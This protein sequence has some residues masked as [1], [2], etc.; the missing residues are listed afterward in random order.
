MLSGYIPTSNIFG[1]KGAK[2]MSSAIPVQLTFELFNPVLADYSIK[3]IHEFV[4]QH[5]PETI[6]D[7]PVEATYAAHTALGMS[8]P[9]L[10]YVG[11][12][13][14]LMPISFYISDL[15][16]GPPGSKIKSDNT[17]EYNNFYNLYEV[18]D[19]FKE[20]MQPVAE[21]KQPPY[22]RVT[23]GKFS[24]FGVI[25]SMEGTE[26]LYF[27]PNGDPKLSRIS[28]QLQPDSIYILDQVNFYSVS[29][30]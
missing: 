13:P 5:N 7:M 23:F 4:V 8:S 19:W 9:T 2:Y 28:L 20:T 11:T 6:T 25:T 26:H 22:V 27:H 10:Q 30:E 1:S 17:I 21:W 15:Y 18:V 12:K 24:R 29:E 3:S 14:G 16:E